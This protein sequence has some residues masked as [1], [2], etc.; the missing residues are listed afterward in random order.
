MTLGSATTVDTN[1]TDNGADITVAAITGGSNNLTLSTGDNISGA[2]ITASGAI[3][4]LGNLTLADVGGTATFS[5]NVAVAAL[6]A[7]STV[8]NI[9]FTGSTNTCLLYTSP[10]P[11]D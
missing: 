2:D 9:T 5:A 6:S 1:A 10:S 8:A 7:D 4:G 11:R 3:S